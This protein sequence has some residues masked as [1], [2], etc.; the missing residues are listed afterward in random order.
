MLGGLLATR[1]GNLFLLMLG[2]SIAEEEDTIDDP[3]PLFSGLG[4]FVDRRTEKLAFLYGVAASYPYRLEFVTPVLG[5]RWQYHP[6]WSLFAAAPFLARTTYSG[7][8]KTKLHFLVA[9][10]G[11]QPRFTNQGVL[12]PEPDVLFLKTKQLRLGVKFDYH[13]SRKTTLAFEAGVLTEGSLEVT[14][15]RDRGEIFST[16]L[17]S[18]GYIQ[19]AWRRSFGKTLTD[20]MG[21]PP[22][23]LP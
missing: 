20:K 2:A 10:A 15:E 23:S 16:D 21:P 4:L 9:F 7:S 22:A 14:T 3:D 6:R 8:E 17:D 11:D 5:V 18:A 19:L 1:K 13:L 12:V